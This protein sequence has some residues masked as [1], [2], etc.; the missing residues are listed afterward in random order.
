MK[1]K[2]K[3][4]KHELESQTAM[5]RVIAWTVCVWLAVTAGPE[6]LKASLAKLKGFSAAAGRPFSDLSLVYKLFLNIGEAKR[7]S[8]D[9]REPGSGSVTQI[10]DD[11]KQLYALGF[12]N[13]IVRQR[14][15]SDAELKGQIA[16][17]VEEIVPRV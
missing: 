15:S 4:E 3:S 16:R 6:Q 8:L 9:E 12:T 13:I 5:I 11:L 2:E 7:S 10:I 14:G 17:F 1:E